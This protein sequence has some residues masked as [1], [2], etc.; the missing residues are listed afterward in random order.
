MYLKREDLQ[1]VR[2]YKIRGAYNF[3]A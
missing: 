2:S 3:I 1:A